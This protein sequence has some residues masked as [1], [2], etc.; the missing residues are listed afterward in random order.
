MIAEFTDKYV[1]ENVDPDER[2]KFIRART[3]IVSL[4]DEMAETAGRISAERRRKI[5]RWGL[6][7]SCV[8]AM[9]RSKGARIV[10]GDKHFDDLKECVKI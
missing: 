10:T 5:K 3:T 7:D 2:L 1:R 6:V 4:D 8:L 9:A